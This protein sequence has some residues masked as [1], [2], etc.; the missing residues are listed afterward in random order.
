MKA[1]LVFV[2]IAVALGLLVGVGCSSYRLAEPRTV[3][4]EAFGA[5]PQAMAQ[6]CVFR[7]SNMALAVTFVVKDNGKLVGATRGPTYFCYFATP[8]AHTIT[9]DSEDDVM[10]AQLDAKAGQRYFLEQGVDNVFG[11]VKSP[12]TWVEASEAREHLGLCDYNVLVGVPG[13]DALPGAAPI[14][15]A[16]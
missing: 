6:V 16:R 15:L 3:P 2:V 10:A 11:F 8:G 14:A 4:I 12:L 13:K 9:S 1:P 7:P 5:P